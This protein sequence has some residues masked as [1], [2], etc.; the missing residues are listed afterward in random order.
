MTV[1]QYLGWYSKLTKSHKIV[2]S[3]PP[4]LH[5]PTDK[6]QIRN[7]RK[8]VHSELNKNHAQQLI[9]IYFYLHMHSLT[10]ILYCACLS[11]HS[12]LRLHVVFL[13]RSETVQVFYHLL[14][15]IAIGDPVIM[16]GG[17]RIPLTGLAPVTFLCLSQART[18]ISKFSCHGL[19]VFS[20]F[21]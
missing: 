18:W 2:Q 16:R 3:T 21:I 8:I 17:V 15:C 9:P 12:F 1:I 20:E 6:I 14:I 4:T 13:S 19:F 7:F 11:C 5:L 10:L